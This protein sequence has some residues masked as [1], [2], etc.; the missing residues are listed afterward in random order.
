[1]K[2]LFITIY[3][4]IALLMMTSCSEHSMAELEMPEPAENATKPI[5]DLRLEIAGR[6]ATIFV[7]S[8]L[9]VSKKHVGM[10]RSAGE[11]HIHMYVDDGEKISVSDSKYMIQNLPPGKHRVKVSLHNNDHTPYDVAKQVDFEIK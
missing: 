6:D 5:L 7:T 4:V 2:K 10:K 8:N 9:R 1:M 11:G 3:L